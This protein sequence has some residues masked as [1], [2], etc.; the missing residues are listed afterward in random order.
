L[1]EFDDNH[2]VLL[3]WA[4]FDLNELSNGELELP[5]VATLEIRLQIIH[6]LFSCPLILFHNLLQVFLLF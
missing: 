3:E 1:D 2:L 4:S 5:Q 6:Q